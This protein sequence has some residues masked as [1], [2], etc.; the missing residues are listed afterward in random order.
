MASV[1]FHF[2]CV[3]MTILAIP[4]SLATMLTLKHCQDQV[5][6]PALPAALLHNM[7]QQQLSCTG[8]QP[9]HF[10]SGL[11]HTCKAGTLT[12]QAGSPVPSSNCCASGGAAAASSC[13]LPASSRGGRMQP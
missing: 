8:R 7:A 1:H 11:L 10:F 9:P 4:N 6:Y 5:L 3:P 2:P 12:S 13:G